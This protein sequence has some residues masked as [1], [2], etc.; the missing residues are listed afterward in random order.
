MSLTGGAE[1]VEFTV[2][3]DAPIAGLTI[4]EAVSDGH[5]DDEMLVVGIEREGDIITAKGKTTIESGD[6]VSLFSK[7]PL[8][9]DSLDGFGSR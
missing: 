4:E 1:V 6:I 7:D 3:E 2:S 9:T 5:L 8:E